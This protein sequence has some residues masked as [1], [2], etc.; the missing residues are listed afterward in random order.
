MATGTGSTGQPNYTYV[1]PWL[2]PRQRDA[3][4][5]PKRHSIIEASSKSGK[6]I[7]CLVWLFEQAIQGKSG[8]N[9]W[10]VA[11]VYPQADIAFRRLRLGLPRHIFTP[12]ESKLTIA[13][14]NGT[15][16][17]FKSAEKPDNLYGE[18]V[19]AAVLDEATRMREEAWYAV[20]TT[21]SATR[22]PVR[23]IG[24]VK[25]RKNWMYALARKA[26]AGE[27]ETHYDKLTWRDA[28]AAGILDAAEVEDAKRSLPLA[29][30]RELYEAEASDDAGNPFGLEAIR[31]CVAPLS[32]D[33]PTA[34][35]WDLAKSVDYTVGIALDGHGHVCRLERFQKSWDDT[36]TTIRDGTGEVRALIDST[37]VGDP[38]VEAL[39]KGGH[40]HLHGFKFSATSKQQIMEGLAVAI[41]QKRIA[42]PEGVISAELES[43]E[44]V[45][46]RTGVHYSAPDG[47][48]DDAVC[49]LALAWHRYNVDHIPLALLG[50][51]DEPTDERARLE[52]G[53]EDLKRIIK[54]QGAY[55]P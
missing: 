15:V 23:I 27:P 14:A 12:N 35:G 22:G 8:R 4:F 18:D 5:T 45:Y 53:A 55:F 7:G 9:Y 20:R 51:Q 19:Y 28:A 37:G 44:Y 40:R 24:N 50:S 42:F 10:W 2:Y 30:W 29:V 34:W 17:W 49:A 26:E 46:T 39:Q 1:R 48:H 31:A 16:I 13:L 38:V 54:E 6:T 47:S 25:G 41:Q 3:I 32:H 52:A 43:F 21:L 36:I 11:P 33:T